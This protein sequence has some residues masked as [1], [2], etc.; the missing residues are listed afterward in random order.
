M[1]LI[2][3][4]AILALAPPLPATQ[5]IIGVSLLKNGYAL[6]V[7]DL[8]TLK[9]TLSVTNAKPEAMR[10][11]VEKEIVARSPRWIAILSAP[12]LRNAAGAPTP[13][14]SSSGTF[15]YPRAGR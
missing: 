3:L 14:T 10:L 11:I 2:V 12:P 6:V 9:G 4:T 7:R 13:C 15:K 1:S 5:R 8:A